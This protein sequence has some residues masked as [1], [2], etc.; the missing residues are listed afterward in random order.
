MMMFFWFVDL[1][2]YINIYKR[3][4]SNIREVVNWFCLCIIRHSKAQDVRVLYKIISV[5]KDNRRKA[6]KKKETA[7]R[8]N[9]IYTVAVTVTPEGM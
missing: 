7:N 6:E 1:Y 5:Y 8:A 9:A 3:L 4:A 2:Y